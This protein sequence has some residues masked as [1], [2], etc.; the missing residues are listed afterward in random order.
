MERHEELQQALVDLLVSLDVKPEGTINLYR[1]GPPLAALGYTQE[2][3]VN[4]LF[5]MESQ[6]N[7]KL[8]DG[9]RLQVLNLSPNRRP[10]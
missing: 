6:R 1:I 8:I 3:M 10:T 9:N 2:E 5:F 7:I 4:T